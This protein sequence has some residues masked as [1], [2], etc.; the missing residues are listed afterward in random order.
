MIISASE[1]EGL[2]QGEKHKVKFRVMREG[3][4]PKKDS[5]LPLR[6]CDRPYDRG[7]QSQDST[8]NLQ[9]IHEATSMY[10]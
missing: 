10:K 2:R 3:G 1:P 7:K 8:G 6:N 4:S 9:H 5:L